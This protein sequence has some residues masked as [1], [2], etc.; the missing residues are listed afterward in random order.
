MATPPPPGSPPPLPPADASA[1]S[2]AASPSPFNYNSHPNSLP[3]L[4]H[5]EF[6][7]MTYKDLIDRYSTKSR[8]VKLSDEELDHG[9]GMSKEEFMDKIKGLK[10]LCS[11][12]INYHL[13]DKETDKIKDKIA[14]FIGADQPLEFIGRWN[15]LRNSLEETLDRSLLQKEAD[16]NRLRPLDRNN[17]WQEIQSNLTAF[18]IMPDT[19]LDGFTELIKQ[20]IK[21]KLNPGE[22]QQVTPDV[23]T[24]EGKNIRLSELFINLDQDLKGRIRS[25]NSRLM[26]GSQLGSQ[27][28]SL[29]FCLILIG[30]SI[31]TIPDSDL[32]PTFSTD[33]NVQLKNIDGIKCLL[34]NI[35]GDVSS[36][37][38]MCKVT[39]DYQRKLSNIR[40][41]KDI[42]DETMFGTNFSWCLKV[43]PAG[44]PGNPFA[45]NT[46]YSYSNV[47][48]GGHF[49]SIMIEESNHE[50][51][52]HV[53]D[54]TASK[55][56]DLREPKKKDSAYKKAAELL[57]SLEQKYSPDTMVNFIAH[58]P[59]DDQT[60][61]S[62]LE[63]IRGDSQ[64]FCRFFATLLPQHIITKSSRVYNSF[65]EMMTGE[66]VDHA[67]GQCGVNNI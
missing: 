46:S 12:D 6:D 21:T 44:G 28:K 65:P 14:N 29:L 63:G 11:L 2:A 66:I 39:P 18:L 47:D 48:N 4:I 51:I 17:L 35:L 36:Q 56:T 31:L 52:V 16:I 3:F 49:F 67:L 1:S 45:I 27:E 50:L 15:K 24:V 20:A 61:G 7:N 58:V 64:S 59:R 41:L 43:K 57:K 30:N 40:S 13:S 26:D 10:E 9:V 32:L 22:E 54:S 25:I 34:Q 23:N 62:S 38:L 19:L 5:Q 37:Q 8:E 53:W 33:L 55:Y 42:V 60:S